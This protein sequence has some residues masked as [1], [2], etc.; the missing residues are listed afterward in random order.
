MKKYASSILKPITMMT[1]LM[2]FSIAF[3]AEND[4]IF[5]KSDY[6]EVLTEFGNAFNAQDIQKLAES[7]CTEQKAELLMLDAQNSVEKVGVWDIISAENVFTKE[8][9]EET[10]ARWV[11]LDDYK[12]QYGDTVR[13]YLV[14]E[15]LEVYQEDRYFHNGINFSLRV[16]AVE[17]G[18]VKVIEDLKAPLRLI[19][20][21]V[22]QLTL[23]KSN[24]MQM[25]ITIAQARTKGFIV[26][27]DGTILGINIA[28]LEKL[29]SEQGLTKEEYCLQNGIDEEQWPSPEKVIG[30][31]INSLAS[32]LGIEIPYYKPDYIRVKLNNGTITTVDFYSY[33]K[34]VL[35]NEWYS[36]DES[37]ALKAGAMCVKMVG[38]FRVADETHSSDGYDVNMSDQT[39]KA[40]TATTNCT[41]AIN[42]ISGI[43]MHVVDG[44]LFYPSYWNGNRDQKGE[45]S[46]GKLEQLGT[47]VLAKEGKGYF[48]ILRYYYDYSSRISYS[49]IAT[50]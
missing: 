17:N 37:E 26:G 36:S 47:Q 22:D 30:K 5:A 24:D 45:Q 29:A 35:P 46:S 27:G 16:L 12:L 34:D 4:P 2:S 15:D 21:E 8:L 32:T 6:E 1:S 25:A 19:E 3:A 49:T 13:G 18:E 23:S 10:L 33:I 39:Y 28:S 43:G 20:S 44:Y 50:F 42:A 9:S 7:Y 41:N 38:W 40:N 11:E 48:D 14:G 31:N